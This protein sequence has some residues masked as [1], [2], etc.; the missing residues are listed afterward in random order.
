MSH[1]NKSSKTTY[2]PHRNLPLLVI[3]QSNQNLAIKISTSQK[4]K[5][6]YTHHVKPFTVC[7]N[8]RKCFLHQMLIRKRAEHR[9]KVVL[10]WSLCATVVTVCY[11]VYWVRQRQ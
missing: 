5:Y 1:V 6:L 11:Y 8:K 10:V 2:F 7:N 9:V 4:Q 3:G